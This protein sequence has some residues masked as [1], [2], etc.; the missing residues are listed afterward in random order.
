MTFLLF[1]IAIG[2]GTATGLLYQQLQRSKE[3]NKIAQQRTQEANKK[4]QA[5]DK[6]YGGLPSREEEVKKLQSQASSLQD[7]IKLLQKQADSEEQEINHK[8]SVLHAKLSELEEKDFVEDFGFYESKYDFKEAVEYKN[9]LDEIRLRQKQLIKNR[10]AAVCETEWTVSG[11]KKEGQRMVDSFLKLVLRAFN[12]ECDAAVGKVKYNNIQTMEKRI[13]K[14]YES[15]NKLSQTTHCEITPEYLDLKIQEL[16]LTYEYQEKRYQEQEEQ[17]QIR[18]QM[19]EEERAQRELERARLEAE[20]EERQYQEALEKAKKEAESA[21]GKLQQELQAKIE[22]LQ[23]RVSEA[24]ANRERAIS[25]AQ[26]TKSGHVY[27]ISNV[28]SFGENIYKIGM[29]RR[30]NPDERV[31]ELSDA[32]VPFPFDIHAMISCSN[33]PELESRLHKMFDSRRLNSVNSRKEFFRVS[34][35]EIAKAVRQIDQELS[36]CTSEIRIAKVAE[37]SEY[38]QSL[39]QARLKHDTQAA[40]VS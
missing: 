38:R 29:T 40:M 16:R 18:E 27:I 35:E 25:Q 23:R 14:A 6:K 4:L 36:T 15:L 9:R 5:I 28:G 39:A 20:K 21:T 37:A 3:E 12:G 34:L 13:Q 17:R 7:R 10:R 24:E 8:I 22:E 26:L 31:K 19:R 2:L 32:S 1:L 11:S 30:L 33:A